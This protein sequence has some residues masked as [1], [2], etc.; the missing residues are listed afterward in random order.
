MKTLLIVED[1]YY[2]RDIYQRTFVKGGYAVDVAADGA[3]AVLKGDEKIYDL[4]LLDIMLPKVTG[5]DVL[6]HLRMEGKP[7]AKT[8][9]YL[10]TNLGQ[11]DII[12]QAF[13]FGADGY[14]IKSQ[15][16]P[17]EILREVETF[18]Q[19]SGQKSHA[20]PGGV[21]ASAAA[22]GSPAPVTPP[23][24][25]PSASEPPTNPPPS[26]VPGDPSST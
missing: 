20:A 5:I 6:K 16:R 14:L 7:N 15:L 10:I 21:A 19:Q 9:I 3:E 17:N 24:A 22:P 2:I 4:I 26:S 11:E 12:K 8:P 18:F 25:Q 23:P 13:S 1:D